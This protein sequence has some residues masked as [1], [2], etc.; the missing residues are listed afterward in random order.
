VLLISGEYDPVTPPRYGD[1]VAADLGNARH[2]V[3]KGQGHSLLGDRL[4][5]EAGRPVHRA[6]GRARRSTPLPRPPRAAAAIFRPARLGT[7]SR[8]GV[9]SD[10]HDR[11]PQSPQDLQVEDRPVRAVD[12]VSFAAQDGRI[13]GLLGPNGAGKTTTCACSTR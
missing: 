10:A 4:H 3:L 13:T 11:G 6:G 8:P 5:A 2:L 7:L 1:E 12:G 9:P